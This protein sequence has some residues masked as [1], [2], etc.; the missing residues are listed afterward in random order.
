MLK[1]WLH[2][3]SK[4][5]GFSS[6]EVLLASTLFGFFATA[7][8]GAVIYG[9][10]ATQDSGDRTAAIMLAD[11]GVQAARNI[12]NGAYGSL[13]NGTYGLTQTG[14][15][16]AFSGN[17]DTIGIY[18]RQITIADKASN[19][20]QVTSTVNWSQGD[21]TKTV[22]V[23]SVLSN[24]IA[25]IKSW[26]NG[27]LAGSGAVSGTANAVK[28]ATSGNYAFTVLSATTSNF[29]VTDMSN[30]A[31]PSIVRTISVTG[32]PSNIAVAGN[33]AYVTTNNGSGEVVVV[34]IATPASAAVA[35]TYNAA[36]TAGALGITISG[37][38]AYITR[39]F[40][41]TDNEFLVLNVTNPLSITQSGAMSSLASMN[42]VYVAGN[43]A[44]VAVS[45]LTAPMAIIN[46]STPASPTLISSFGL[47]VLANALSVGG[48]GKYVYLAASYTLYILDIT[49]PATPT[50]VKQVIG[51]STIND[52]DEDGDKSNVFLGTASTAGEFQVV[53]VSSPT[54][55]YAVRTI[56]VPGTASAIGGVAYNAAFDA[57]A[58]ASASDT[59]EIMVFTRN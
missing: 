5:R 2:I 9:R 29:V 11:E 38:Y 34:N 56:D 22:S 52:I 13:V 23:V 44:Y 47:S 49:N 39:A 36:G 37:N 25:T 15:L 35:A 40:S 14:N 32:T 24:W 41:L 20:K 42:E 54:T 51:A 28:V 48:Y 53:D 46:I 57:V 31:A 21:D 19:Q 59:Q 6:V 50:L 8:I 55:A 16:W 58:A 30:P 4:T 43:Y 17:S 27:I 18:N 7:L 12:R 26:A 10:A 33:Y 3:K 45:S 1:A